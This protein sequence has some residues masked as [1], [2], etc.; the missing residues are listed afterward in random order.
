M[1]RKTPLAPS[2][3]LID[4]SSL[5]EAA[6]C[7][8][9]RFGR[10]K[11]TIDYSNLHNRLESFRKEAG[12]RPSTLSSIVLSIDPASEGQQ[13]FQQ[14]LK[15]SGF[16]PDV[17]YYRDAFAS[18]PPGRS[19]VDSSIK[20]PVSLA[21]RL[22][23]ISGLMAREPSSELLIV[24]HAYELHGPLVDLSERLT[25]GNVGVA[26]FSSLV[27]YRWKLAGLIENKLSIQFFDLDD[28]GKELVEVDLVGKTSE[29]HSM[30]SGLKRF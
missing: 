19:P 28:Y 18:L 2:V 14:M 12:W 7:I 3:T 15:H 23:Y 4:G 27:D 13:R 24:T 5:F 16:E 8:G 29:Q 10:Q 30:A 20:S 1:G 17:V 11:I 22:A 25:N 21:S 6:E 9:D 26:Y